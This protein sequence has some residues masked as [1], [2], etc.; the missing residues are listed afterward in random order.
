MRTGGEDEDG[1]LDSS[2]GRLRAKGVGARR[3]GK[4]S[5]SRQ[6]RGILA[7]KRMTSSGVVPRIHGLEIWPS[8]GSH[9]NWRLI[10]FLSSCCP[11]LTMVVNSR[12]PKSHHFKK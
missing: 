2:P 7:G 8:F 6:L 3:P 9:L 4:S 5:G 12:K 10:I 11:L 1:V